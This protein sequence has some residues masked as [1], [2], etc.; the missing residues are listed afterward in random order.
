MC[1][2][3]V[4]INASVNFIIYSIMST[5]FRLVMASLWNT[6][7]NKLSILLKLKAFTFSCVKD[8][9]V[10]YEFHNINPIYIPICKFDLAAAP[11]IEMID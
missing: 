2:L 11:G 5:K 6:A 7:K 9:P 8:E 10:E 1:N 3:L 4:M